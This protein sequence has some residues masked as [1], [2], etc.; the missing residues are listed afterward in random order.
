MA[1]DR[2]RLQHIHSSIP[3]KQPTP[4]SIDVGEIAV[5]NAANQEFISLKNTEDK[6]VR[7]S[8]D[9]QMITWTEKKE[10]MP[11]EGQV[12]GSVGPDGTKDIW[13]SYGITDYDLRTNKSN[14]V[15]KLNQ[16]A[17]NNTKKHDKVNGATDIYS[18][19]VNPTTDGGLTDGAGFAI[20]MS[21]Y[22]M[23][24]GNPEFSGVT[25]RCYTNLYGSTKIEGS[26]QCGALLEINMGEGNINIDSTNTN[27]VSAT[28]VIGTEDL[29]VNGTTTEAHVGN[30]TITNQANKVETTNGT[31]TEVHGGQVTVNN[32]ADFDMNTDGDAS[33]MTS[34][35]TVIHSNGAVGITAVDDIT[36]VSSEASIY[37]TANDDLC[38][39][40]GDIAAIK[41][42]NKTNVGVDC[43]DGVRTKVTNLYGETINERADVA[44]T[45][46]ASAYTSAT[47]ATEVIGTANATV[48]TATLNGEEL[49]VNETD[50]TV[51]GDTLA[52]GEDVSITADAPTTT[53][54]GTNFILNE[55]NTVISSCTKIELIT[56][57]FSI[58]QCSE[59]GGGSA[60]YKF[61]NGYTIESNNIELKECDEGE[62][63]T[64]INS[65]AT[66]VSGE[67]LT[68]NESGTIG[69]N[70][71]TLTT[72]VSGNAAMSVSG[73]TSI[74]TSGTTAIK[75][76]DGTTIQTTAGNTNINTTGNT[77]IT[78]TGE[79]AIT[80]VGNT[81]IEATGDNS[82]VCITAK[83]SARV[84]GKGSTYVGVKCDGTVGSATTV[85]GTTLT[86]NGNTIDVDA[87]DYDLDATNVCVNGATKA[88]FYGKATNIGV[89]CNGTIATTT[90]VKGTTVNVSGDTTN[91]SGGTI[92]Q[93]S[94]GKTCIQAGSDL[95]IG[96]D[97]S[98]KIGAN[99]AGSAYSNNT[100]IYAQT[101]VT[102]NA[103]TTN[104][105]GKTNISGDTVVGGNL[106]V[107]GTVY[108][109]KDLT[110]ATGTTSVQSPYNGSTA[111][112]IKIPSD[113]SHVYRSK[114]KIAYG[115]PNTGVTL[116]DP[117]SGTANTDRSGTTITIPTSIGDLANDLKTLTVQYGTDVSNRTS[118]ATFNG[119]AN[120]TIGVPTT[121]AQISNGHVKDSAPTTTTG[122]ITIDKTT[123]ISKAATVAS[124]LTVSSNGAKI[125][126]ATSVNGNLSVSGT[127]TVT[128]AVYSSDVN[129]K[130]NIKRINNQ[131]LDNVALIE[132][133]SYNFKNDESK[134]K[135]Y[136]VIAQEVQ[137]AGLGELVYTNEDGS[138]AVD[139]TSLTMLK[140][141]KLTQDYDNLLSFFVHLQNKVTEIEE[142]IKKLENK[143]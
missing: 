115:T 77:N 123:S 118:A 52:I 12:R 100:T 51:S 62:G 45:R 94:T 125:T 95:N 7:L 82:D 46:V 57:D 128:Q 101:A 111:K 24:E 23:I 108:G 138:L 110:I 135:L 32:Q 58:N 2:R 105:T 19:E 59:G 98:T 87:T 48:T 18:N 131:E 68:I 6:V 30:V 143:D 92:N 139:Y 38:A 75:T 40:A 60:E 71:E 93:T 140:L 47:T 99:C 90:T 80:S 106:S 36:A 83:D 129:L 43:T 104:I 97:T 3:D 91:I 130:E 53:F 86:L 21:R 35:N 56:N 64:I 136:G 34:G 14:I 127:V 44:D 28:T 122:T 31:T 25:S 81:T 109:L 103:P 66:S 63:N 88:N 133:K 96:G 9:E 55:A 11:Y 121:L 42:V 76:E 17:A 134:H 69:I 124:G 5:N 8:S 1:K 119:S 72:A 29:T 114:L 112:S 79:A 27:I 117:G 22:A 137:G 70:G 74:N 141:A 126:G 54:N 26:Y 113:A 41:G 13:G 37:I 15:I 10:V 73:N 50:I 89:E 78:S 116:Y 102:V 84:Y 33:F 65:N 49:N 61:C 107:S 85:E 4:A 120:T 67:S 16:V 142:K 20:D 39:T 132:Y